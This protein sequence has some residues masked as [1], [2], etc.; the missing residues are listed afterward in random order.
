[1][2]QFSTHEIRKNLANLTINSTLITII[3][4]GIK[5]FLQIAGITILSRLLL[6]TDFGLMYMVNSIFGFLLIFNDL[7]LSMGSVQKEN[8]K[9][10]QVSLLFWINFLFSLIMCIIGIAIAPFLAKFYHK[11]QILN[12]AILLSLGFI[13]NGLIAQHQALLK[14]KMCFSSLAISDLIS[15]IFGVA[16]GISSAALGAGYR[17]LVYMQ[18]SRPIVYMVCIILFTAWIPG[19]PKMCSEIKPILSFGSYLSLF[20]MMNYFLR[21]ID[22]ILIGRV[23]GEAALGFYGKAYELLMMPIQN[24]TAPLANVFIP[25]LSRLQEDPN[26]Y[27]IYYQQFLSFLFLITFPVVM[28][29]IMHSK[30]I[31]VIFLG[32]QWHNSNKIF[33]YLSF[34]SIAQVVCTTSGWLYTSLG[35][36]KELFKYGSIGV[37]MFVTSF[38]LGLPYGATGVAVT[39]SISMIVWLTPC[40]FFATRNTPITMRLIFSEFFVHLL[41]II[42][43]GS[44]IFLSSHF[45]K[46]STPL[47]RLVITSILG[48]FIYYGIVV[49]LFKRWNTFKMLIHYIWAQPGKNKELQKNEKNHQKNLL[50]TT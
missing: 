20:S 39:Y 13:P 16:T 11:P 49:F 10:E 24:I 8:L 37:I 7:G 18:L 42:V 2:E 25:A 19:L 43:G 46:I 6:P 38:F 23:W 32:E 3:S 17:S 40:M 41:G 14:R 50:G 45:L 29:C 9:Q 30:E 4:Q 34:G 21:N 15:I 35:R 5:I 44:T 1:M 33:S 36:T 27:K 28:I 26:R 47:F 12:V 31:I 22:N 48:L